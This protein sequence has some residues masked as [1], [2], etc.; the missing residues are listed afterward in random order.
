MAPLFRDVFATAASDFEKQAAWRDVL[1]SDFAQKAK[2][3]GKQYWDNLSGRRVHALA[4]EAAP[5]VARS[6]GFAGR[7]SGRGERDLNQVVRDLKRG[8]VSVKATYNSKGTHFKGKDG[9]PTESYPFHANSPADLRLM[10]LA[11]ARSSRDVTRAGTLGAG[12]LSA[13]SLAGLVRSKKKQK[14]PTPSKGL[15]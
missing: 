4:E 13:A 1:K 2:K 7:P 5:R 15:P 6:Y 14:P 12:T 11:D 8:R 9:G 3:V 10:R